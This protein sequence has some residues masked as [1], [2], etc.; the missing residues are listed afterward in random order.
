MG[1][2]K[3]LCCG[4]GLVDAEEDSHDICPICGWEDDGIQA[5]DPDYDGGPNDGSSLNE[6]RKEF[7][8]KRKNNPKYTWTGEAIEMLKD[9]YGEDWK[10][11]IHKGRKK[12]K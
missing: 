5:D 7:Q 11:V 9:K 10:E 8:E 3:C 4:I 6:Y 2:K 12:P 1:Y